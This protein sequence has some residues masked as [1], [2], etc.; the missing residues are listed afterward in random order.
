MKKR[1]NKNDLKIIREITID[2]NKCIN[3]EKIFSNISL[4]IGEEFSEDTAQK[5]MKAIF[6][7]GFFKDVEMKLVS[8]WML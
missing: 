8:Q 6:D 3:E 2:G 1:A 7:M 4:R 5:D